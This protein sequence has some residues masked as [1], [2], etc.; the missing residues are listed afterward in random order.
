MKIKSGT[1]LGLIAS[2]VLFVAVAIAQQSN[3]QQ[4]DPAM[5]QS[6]SRGEQQ[7]KQQGAMTQDPQTIKQVQQ[8]LSDKGYYKGTADGKMSSK[9][10]SALKQFQQ[11]QG[12][13]ATGQLDQQTLASLGVQG[14]A[15]AGGQQDMSSSRQSGGAGG[16]Q[17]SMPDQQSGQMNGNQ[18]RGGKY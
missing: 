7:M 8:A 14:G 12:M 1:V 18:Q 9:T 17:G 4:G 3:G 2:L 16:Q 5:Q 10:E 6:R 11:A 15:A 13:Q